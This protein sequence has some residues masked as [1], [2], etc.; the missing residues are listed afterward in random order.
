MC[1]R[2]CI[3]SR[4]GMPDSIVKAAFKNALEL[5][6]SSHEVL[7]YDTARQGDQQVHRTSSKFSDSKNQFDTSGTIH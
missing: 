4:Y 3:L 7:R 5:D 1:D 2:G 6:E